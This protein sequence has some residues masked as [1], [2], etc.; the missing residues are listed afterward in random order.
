[1]PLLDNEGQ[2]PL[3]LLTYLFFIVILPTVVFAT[4][5]WLTKIKPLTKL[6]RRHDDLDIYT[7]M[8]K[9]C[10]VLNRLSQ[11]RDLSDDDLPSIF[12]TLFVLHY[13]ECVHIVIWEKL[14]TKIV[15][16]AH[17]TLD[18]Y[19]D[20]VNLHIVRTTNKTILING[21]Y[22]TYFHSCSI[23]VLVNL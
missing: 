9:Y 12:R 19:F 21:Q 5:Y 1:M 2:S 10:A 6:K 4:Y 22:H 17:Y 14:C 23:A 3:L 13:K 18:N 7:F 15:L 8:N 20:M 11:I 16:S